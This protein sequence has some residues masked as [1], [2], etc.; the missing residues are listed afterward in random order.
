M[1]NLWDFSRPSLQ[2]SGVLLHCFSV[3]RFWG[4]SFCSNISLRSLFSCECRKA[5]VCAYLSWGRFSRSQPFI[6]CFTLAWSK[7]C[8]ATTVIQVSL[9]LWPKHCTSVGGPIKVL[10]SSL[11]E[12][13]PLVKDSSLEQHILKSGFALPR[14]DSLTFSLSSV[15][16]C[17]RRACQ[18]VSA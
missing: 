7:K 17:F 12:L 6:R 14:V 13:Q 9:Q 11:W 10:H 8:T 5:K 2:Y 4:F 16:G 15:D 18:Y 1:K 3:L